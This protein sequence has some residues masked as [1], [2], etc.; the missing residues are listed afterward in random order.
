MNETEPGKLHPISTIVRR[1]SDIFTEMGFEIADGP[2]IEDQWHNFDALNV[3]ENHPARDMQDT[4]FVRGQEGNVLRTHTSNVQIRFMEEFFKAGNKPPFK[5]IAP[6]QVFRNEATD[7]THEA[8]FHQVEGLVVGKGI[9]LAHL[10][11]TLEEFLSRFYGFD[12]ESRFRPG[13]FPFVEPGVE[14][15]L[16]FQD[17]WL[18]MLGAGMVHPNVLRNVGLDPEEYSGFAFGMGI[19]RLTMMKLGIPDVRLFYTGDLRLHNGL[20]EQEK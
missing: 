8:Q 20:K 9:S 14:V 13:F 4:F 10:K 19:D 15:D 5:I 11:G 3:P 18:E 12:V 2:L 16:K 1:I 17:R 7:A 6:G